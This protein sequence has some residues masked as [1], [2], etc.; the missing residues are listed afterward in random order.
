MQTRPELILLQKTMVV[1]E[2]VARSLDPDFDMWST[3][4]PV[5]R[6]WL[7]RDLGAAAR[8]EQAS[9]LVGSFGR[10]LGQLPELARRAERIS[11]ELDRMG[12]QGLRLDQ[13]TIDGI[14]SR[15]AHHDRSHRFALWTIAALLAAAVVALLDSVL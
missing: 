1:V 15:I 10:L 12:G 9:D 4:E 3:A 13:T 11:A 8:L 2:G 5:V 14:G 7:E 6:G